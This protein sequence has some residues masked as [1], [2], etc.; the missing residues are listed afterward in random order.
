MINKI[1]KIVKGWLGIQPQSEE[2]FLGIAEKRLQAFLAL[3][4]EMLDKKMFIEKQR[5]ANEKA[6]KLLCS[7]KGQG[8]LPYQVEK[9]EEEFLLEDKQFA[10][11]FRRILNGED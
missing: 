8:L 7:L 6:K 3:E 11:E 9:L 10:E 4:Q 2:P 5:A 1:K